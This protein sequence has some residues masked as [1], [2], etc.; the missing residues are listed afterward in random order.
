MIGRVQSF[1]GHLELA[2]ARISCIY[3]FLNFASIEQLGSEPSI[4]YKSR[5]VVGQDVVEQGNLLFRARLQLLG[6]GAL[7]R[8]M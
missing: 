8:K 4:Y 2:I 1:A 7:A 6:H 3:Q 5:L